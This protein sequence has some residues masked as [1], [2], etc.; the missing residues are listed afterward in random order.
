MRH[1]LL[2]FALGCAPTV[3][4]S[5]GSGTDAPAGDGAH[6]AD[7]DSGTPETGDGGDS[8]GDDGIDD[9]GGSALQL[10]HAGGW[11]DDGGFALTVTTALVGATVLTTRDGS[12]PLRSPTATP[13]TAPLDIDR[14]TVVRL[15]LTTDGTPVGPTV[16]R[17]FVFPDQV[18]TQAAPDDWPTQWSPDYGTGGWSTPHYGLSDEI[19]EDDPAGFQAA[20]RALPMLSLVLDPGD[21]WGPTG[22]Y[23]HA[24]ESGTAWERPLSLELYADGE[25][26]F[27][28]NAG[29]RIYG[30]ASRQPDRSPKKSIRV[31]F[32]SDYGPGT[33][34]YPLY[35]DAGPEQFDGLVL[36]V[37]YNHSW[38]HWDPT[39]R[40]RAQ[41]LRDPYARATQRALGGE[42]PRGRHVHLFLNGLY[43]GIYDIAE[44]ADADFFADRA[45]GGEWDVLNSG[46][47]IDGDTDDWDETLRRAQEA[48]GSDASLDALREKVDEGALIDYMLMNLWAGNDD[49]PWH[50]WYAGRQR[51][52]D[53]RWRFV[54]WDAE[55]TLKELG[56]DRTGADDVGTPGQVFQ[57]FALHGAFR[58]RLAARAAEVM[59]DG[60]VL[61]PAIAIARYDALADILGPAMLAESARW[62]SYRR[63]VYCYASAPCELY[64]VDDHWTPERDRITDAYLP[65]RTAVVQDQ[66]AARGWWPE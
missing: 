17:T 25:E 53:G 47:A 63:D 30:G 10:D 49:W 19:T 50:N 45:G 28:I 51:S 40:S 48:D 4:R 32:K 22:L 18:E 14:T 35:E 26:E 1:L 21:L 62:G 52:D 33:L 29:G 8:D 23:D 9:V 41:L 61:S 59:G 54:S 37:G 13:Y 39:Q 57:A 38:V 24:W 36:R 56:T 20:L 55:H 15:A 46:E 2:A 6:P 27:A 16:T 5:T 44:R 65:A 31:L 64:T 34:R 60:G 7:H 58:D 66:L 43:W 42:A 11:V 3:P 12:D